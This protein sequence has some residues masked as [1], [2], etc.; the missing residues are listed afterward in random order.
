MLA[1]TRIGTISRNRSL[2]GR[3]EQH[4]ADERPR[5]R[6]DDATAE[7]RPEPG[8]IVALGDRAGDVAGA[9]ATMF[10]ALAL[11]AGTP[12]AVSVGKLTS[13]PPPALAL[14]I[15]P[16]AAATPART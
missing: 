1:R 16:T 13:V 12:I 2:A 6:A 10:V 3:D 14:I 5:R 4:G 9:H 15:A 11:R 8:Q 7:A